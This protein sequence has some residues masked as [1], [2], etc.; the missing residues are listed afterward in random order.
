M[1]LAVYTSTVNYRGDDRLDIT[2]AG[3]DP[4]GKYFAPTWEMVHEYRRGQVTAEEYTTR[5]LDRMRESYKAHRWAWQTLLARERV[6]LVC[7]CRPGAFCHRRLLARFL[8]VF[9]AADH[10]EL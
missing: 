5:Y 2:A 1:P 9:G 4:L 3:Q 8:T 10:G 7:Y 6:V